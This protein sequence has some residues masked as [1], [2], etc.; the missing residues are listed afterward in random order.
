MIILLSIVFLCCQQQESGCTNTL[1][2]E[3]AFVCMCKYTYGERNRRAFAWQNYG[4]IYKEGLKAEGWLVKL[5]KSRSGLVCIDEEGAGK[6]GEFALSFIYAINT[7]LIQDTKNTEMSNKVR[8]NPSPH[9][10][11]NVMGVHRK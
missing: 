6:L 9:G 7:H 11:H 3:G 8:E 1:T 4:R 2:R 10:I 5:L